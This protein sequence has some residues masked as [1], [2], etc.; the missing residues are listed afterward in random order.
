MTEFRY[1]GTAA[2]CY[3]EER[4][5]YLFTGQ[6]HMQFLDDV[7]WSRGREALTLRTELAAQCRRVV[8]DA[9]Y[10]AHSLD[11]SARRQAEGRGF[12]YQPSDRTS[13]TDAV[14]ALN[15]REREL[16]ELCRA[17]E[18]LNMTIEGDSA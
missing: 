12:V 14:I 13:L 11:S 6:A 3:V 9:G 17:A 8:D 15:A 4:F 5:E 7:I 16:E 18:V 1:K 10:V 2:A